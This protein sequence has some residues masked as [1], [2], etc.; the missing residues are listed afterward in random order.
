MNKGIIIAIALIIVASAFC[1]CIGDKETTSEEP[2]GKLFV[3]S[4]AGLR[5]SRKAWTRS[6]RSLNRNMGSR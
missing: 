5:E 6:Q 1:G 4:G 2:N 3:Y